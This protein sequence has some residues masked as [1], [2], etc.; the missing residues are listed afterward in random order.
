MGNPN[1]KPSSHQVVEWRRW[2]WETKMAKVLLLVG[3]EWW[4]RNDGMVVLA[5]G[6]TA[7]SFT[8]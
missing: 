1:P 6:V 2:G 7:A 5:L 4:W 8:E 3:G